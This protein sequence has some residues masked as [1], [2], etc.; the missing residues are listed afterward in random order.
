M[1]TR[2]AC[3]SWAQNFSSEGI[4]IRAAYGL[5]SPAQVCG[6]TAANFGFVTHYSQLDGSF[7]ARKLLWTTV[8]YEGKMVTSCAVPTLL[9]AALRILSGGVYSAMTRSWFTRCPLALVLVFS[10]VALPASAEWKEKVL[11]SFLGGTTDGSVPAGGVVF[12]SEGNL[13][14]ATTHGGPETC[15]PI[16]SACGT[17]FEL[18]PPTQRGGA[19]TETLIYRFQGE[20]SQDGSV[21]TGGLIFDTAG[22]LFGVTGYGGTGDCVLVEIKA[23]C[24]TVFELSPPQQKGGAWTETILYSFRSGSDGYFPSGNLVFDQKGNLYGATEFGGGEGTT[25]DPI[26]QYCGTVFKLTPPKEKD[27]KWEE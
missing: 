3:F 13:Y 12:D 7:S 27:G 2:P 6:A 11:Y 17:A 9:R 1:P 26:Y 4:G 16:G 8:R 18:T 25:C 23:G 20:G 10:V 24:G 15:T 21:P 14:G 5:R 22:N 19:W